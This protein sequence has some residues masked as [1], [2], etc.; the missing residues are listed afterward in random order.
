VKHKIRWWFQRRVR[1]YLW[2]TESLF[3]RHK[4]LKLEPGRLYNPYPEDFL[5]K[6]NDFVC[7][8]EFHL[9][10]FPRWWGKCKR[11]FFVP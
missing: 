5:F 11:G 1:P 4:S 10:Y 9:K 7:E 8:G 6:W 3:Y 2:G